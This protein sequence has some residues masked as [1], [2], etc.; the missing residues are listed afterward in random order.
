VKRIIAYSFGAIALYLVVANATG[1]GNLI[2][3]TTAGGASL[4]SAFQGRAS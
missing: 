1:A 3:D 2:K 4:V